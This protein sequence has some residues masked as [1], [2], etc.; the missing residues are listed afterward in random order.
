MSSRRVED[1]LKTNKCLLGRWENF[2]TSAGYL[3][4]EEFFELFLLYAF[5]F[6]KL[7]SKIGLLKN[8]IKFLGKQL[9]WSHKSFQVSSTYFPANFV[10]FLVH[11][12]Y[13]T[14]LSECFCFLGYFFTILIHSINVIKGILKLC[15]I[16]FYTGIMPIY[17][18]IFALEECQ[19]Y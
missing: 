4:N 5:F 8:F 1:V 17:R 11:L 10:R 16:Y 18:K 3:C 2:R 6:K 14:P 19:N 9:C 15:L 7:V 13:R 12:F